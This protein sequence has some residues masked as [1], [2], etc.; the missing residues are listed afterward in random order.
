VLEVWGSLTRIGPAVPVCWGGVSAVSPSGTGEAAAARLGDG[1]ARPAFRGGASGS[2]RASKR[3]EAGPS[4]HEVPT[5][6]VRRASARFEQVRDAPAAHL[7]PKREQKC[8]AEAVSS[9][10]APH[11]PAEWLES[12]RDHVI[13]LWRRNQDPASLLVRCRLGASI[14][15]GPNVPS[16]ERASTTTRAR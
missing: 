11:A 3:A 7:R 10:G 14:G 16:A 8:R 13:G 6:A 1:D 12:D 9:S 5:G 15:P 2:A 4:P